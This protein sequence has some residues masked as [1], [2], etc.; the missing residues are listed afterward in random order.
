[1]ERFLTIDGVIAAQTPN[2]TF[3]FNKIL[4]NF[5]SIIEIGYNR[6]AFSKW[7]HLN[8]RN[9]SKL[10]C[11]DIIDTDRE[12]FD[13][14]IDFRVFDC[15]S[16][17]CISEIKNIISYSGRTLVLCDGGNKELEFKIYSKFLKKDDVIMLHDYCDDVNE[18][19]I[20]INKINWATQYESMYRNII[21]AIQDNNLNKYEYDSFKNVLWGS[22]IKL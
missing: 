10:F 14:D 18:Y 4:K 21:D 13:S 9:D 22:F 19:N 15:L 20:L 6:G 2:V 8:K 17:E 1:M 11:Y 5:D 16:S 3:E 12:I 7:L